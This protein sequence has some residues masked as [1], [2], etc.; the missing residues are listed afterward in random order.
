[1]TLP[2]VISRNQAQKIQ[3]IEI[4][5][6][7]ILQPNTW[8]TCPTGKKAI[9]KG[10]VQVTSRG[11]AANASFEVAGTVMFRWDRNTAVVDSAINA[12]RTLTT[13]GGGQFA[14][15]EVE[16]AA[17]DIIRTIQNTGTNAEF[18]VWASVAETPA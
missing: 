15:F 13:S 12:P 8:Y 9:V 7:V 6:R 4:N 16:L 11:A 14:E 2:Q 18:N 10:R 17:G 1:M 3:S 5:G